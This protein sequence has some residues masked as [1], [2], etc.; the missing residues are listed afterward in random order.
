M[1]NKKNF[2]PFLLLILII[3]PNISYAYLGLGALVPFIGNAL[4]L[5]FVGFITVLAFLS[6]PLKKFYDIFLKKKKYK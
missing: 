4:I 6:Y 3:I 1:I 2:F 5:I